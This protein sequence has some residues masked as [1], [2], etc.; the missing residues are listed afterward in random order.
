ML[1]LTAVLVAR[2]LEDDK[3]RLDTGETPNG[4]NRGRAGVAPKGAGMETKREPNGAGSI[5]TPSTNRG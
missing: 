5:S 3:H 4:K 1:K 2:N